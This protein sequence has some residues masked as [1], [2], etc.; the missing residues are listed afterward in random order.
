MLDCPMSLTIV[1]RLVP[2]KR[3]VHP[4]ADHPNSSVG[5]V[6]HLVYRQTLPSPQKNNV[7]STICR[8][9]LRFR[10]CHGLYPLWLSFVLKTAKEIRPAMWVIESCCRGGCILMQCMLAHSSNE[11]TRRLLE[12]ASSVKMLETCIFF[13][14]HRRTGQ[15]ILS[16][17]PR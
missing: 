17:S 14:C 2:Q 3:L 11:L 6:G 13:I 4:L 9:Q 1:H 8:N 15:K 7:Y 10:Q 5:A 16:H 12:W